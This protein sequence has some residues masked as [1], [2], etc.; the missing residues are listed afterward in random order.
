MVLVR[1]GE[2]E[3]EE[4]GYQRILAK[5]PYEL[6]LREDCGFL[7]RDFPREYDNDFEFFVVLREHG[8]DVGEKI[9]EY[10]S[11]RS[12][13]EKIEEMGVDFEDFVKVAY[14]TGLF[15]DV[16]KARPS[17]QERI[18]EEFSRLPP[19]SAHSG[20]YVW[21]YMNQ[22]LKD[23]DWSV[24]M[25]GVVAVIH[26]H[27]NALD[28]SMDMEG[29]FRKNAFHPDYSDIDGMMENLEKAGFRAD[30]KINEASVMS[31][32]R[33]ITN[34]K[35]MDVDSDNYEKLGFLSTF[36]LSFLV[37][38]DH[39]VSAK[40]KGDS[41]PPVIYDLEA[42]EIELYDSLRPYQ[43]KVQDS[44]SCNTDLIG[45]AGCG[46][47]KTHSAFQWAKELCERD[48]ISRLVFAMPTQVTA[49]NM[50]VSVTG[51]VHDNVVTHVDPERTGLY[52]NESSDFFEDERN[53]NRFD[54]GNE[55]KQSESCK[56]FKNA[57]TTTTV[58][59][60]LASLVNGY[61]GS[62][63]A[64][65]NLL[66]SGVVFDEVHAYDEK[67]TSN[68]LRGIKILRKYNIPV[69]II[70]ATLPPQLKNHPILNDITVIQSTGVLE[71]E[72][73]T[74]REP[75]KFSLRRAEL[76]VDSILKEANN[77]EG[78]KKI[79]VVVNKVQRA[80]K[81]ARELHK[82]GEEVECYTAE[83]AKVD[84]Q[85]KEY[86]IRGEFGRGSPPVSENDNID[87]NRKFL[88][89][90][91]VCEIS[92]DLSADLLISDI[93]PIDSILQRAGRLHR[94]GKEIKSKECGCSQCQNKQEKGE[95]NHVYECIVYSPLRMKE[96][97]KWLPYSQ[98]EG[99]DK[100]W[101]IL[102]KT[103]SS[104]I[105]YDN[106]TFNISRKMVY[107]VY[108]SI[109]MSYD[110]DEYEKDF[111]EDLLYGEIR[112][113]E[114]DGKPDRHIRDIN[115][116][117]IKILPSNYISS[118]G[119]E[120]D[121]ERVWKKYHDEQWDKNYDKIRKMF[122]DDVEKCEGHEE[123]GIFELESHNPCRYIFNKFKRKY[124]VKMKIYHLRDENFLPEKNILVI[125]DMPVPA[126][127]INN[128]DTEDYEIIADVD[129]DYV[130]GL[131]VVK[132]KKKKKRTEYKF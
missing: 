54:D 43:E 114:E 128:P 131:D 58:D 125:E 68:L 57:V 16:G 130:F 102:R 2:G 89:S 8:L 94:D 53:L 73:D 72:D 93:A 39:H 78:A 99:K 27:G 75:Y 105:T 56:Y 61:K 80:K 52:H 117:S 71:S 60:V 82:K 98:G 69:Y 36:L 65:A 100:E 104:L 86:D 112:T 132:K 67:T 96:N 66:T 77:K 35:R 123:C 22:N 124:S 31:F 95:D 13:R 44:I 85:K 97:N 5:A 3:K 62:S 92:L 64:K 122:G 87:G 26:H 121:I 116:R 70:T 33:V 101:D 1:E 38:A 59:H 23:I 126:F 4:K 45:V 30:V 21:E 17:W 10:V 115:N 37:Q 83:M 7:R 11:R 19:H 109:S 118:E 14:F 24:K 113:D 103:E 90:T 84:R 107:D 34:W 91:Q 79:M 25:A 55:M 50:I 88:V 119:I 49:N 111:R 40:E 108:N 47:G 63:I 9:V 48:E 15:H 46:E 29:E 42:S 51:G 106:Y 81:L 6:E 41:D 20:I 74:P 28:Y 127:D 129:Y 18:R 32:K 76:N 110:F 120:I 12:V